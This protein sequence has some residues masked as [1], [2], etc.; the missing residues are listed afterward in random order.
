MEP[1]RRI[2][3]HLQEDQTANQ[4][5]FCHTTVSVVSNASSRSVESG[6]SIRSIA[7]RTSRTSRTSSSSNSSSR[8]LAS[9][10]ATDD[11]CIKLKRHDTDEWLKAISALPAGPGMS[12]ALCDTPW[13]GK[14]VH[15]IPLP[16]LGSPDGW[17]HVGI[18]HVHTD[19]K[20]ITILL[21]L[22]TAINLVPSFPPHGAAV[23][24]RNCGTDTR[25]H[26]LST[27]L[28]TGC[29]TASKSCTRSVLSEID[30]A[31][32]HGG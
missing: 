25:T 3:E 9:R 32:L 28:L 20:L 6:D 23:L 21:M 26:Y 10:C 24:L 2:I 18:I 27:S 19:M 15:K 17:R 16:V 31:L 5:S 14:P 22:T 7:S 12:Q 11:S 8:I 13:S 29:T 4:L 30:P 1:E